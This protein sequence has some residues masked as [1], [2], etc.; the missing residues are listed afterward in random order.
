[1]EGVLITGGNGLLG[2]K[3]AHMLSIKG[4][5][6]KILTRNPKNT[7]SS[8]EYF[9]DYSKQRID[10]EALS[11]IHHV[12]HLAGANVGEKRWSANQKLEIVNSRVDSAS[13]LLSH[14]IQ[15]N[16]QLKSFIS[17]SAIGYYGNG[18]MLKDETSNLGA[19]FLAEVCE[20]WEKMADNYSGIS[21]NVAK[22][23]L[24]VVF[25][26]NEGAFPKII[27]P[28]KFSLLVALGGGNQLYSWI[29]ID[30]ASGF[31]VYALENNLSGTY[32]VCANPPLPLKTILSNVTKIIGKKTISVPAPAFFLRLALGEQSAI[33]LDS[34]AANNQKM[35]SS[36]YPFK[37]PTLE[38]A[39]SE[40]IE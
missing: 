5:D 2:K 7:P 27:Q 10:T 8:N 26:K 23:R 15:H 16:I 30:D 22:L 38:M 36:G 9:W 3:I 12:I 39:L 13:F 37:Y 28:L 20:Q 34:I 31:F 4:Y 32:N 24:G 18:T 11:G 29:H 19:G 35:L 1:M 14:L 17:A 40:L 21:K 25:D 6:I 33:V